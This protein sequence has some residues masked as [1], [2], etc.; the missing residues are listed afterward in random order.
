MPKLIV[1]EG[2][3]KGRT[4]DF[5]GEMIFLGRSRKNDIQ[6]L[7]I[8]VSRKHLKIFKIGKKCF[9]EDLKS[10][11]GTLING[12]K[13]IPG[14]SFEVGEDDVITLGHTAM[15][16]VDFPRMKLLDRKLPV[17]RQTEIEAVKKAS[18]S[19]G[20]R[21]SKTARE[22]EL[23]NR[24]SKL[25]KQSFNMRGFLEK[26]LE[27]VMD[28]LPRIDTAA[29]VLLDYRRDGRGSVKRVFTRIR[30][31]LE[32]RDGAISQEVIDQVIEVG[33]SIRMSD[34]SYELRENIAET[35]D[36]LRVGSVMCV[37]M[38]SNSVM[39]GAIYVDSVKGPYG[40]RK[41]DLLLLNSLSGSLA[42]AIEKALLSSR[43]R[44]S[45]R[46]PAKT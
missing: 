5:H 40:F 19:N 17:A 7:D 33:E 10:T 28:S 3:M 8:S 43:L 26:V 41:D 6:L 22:L 2:S 36:T 4:F 32:K 18:S 34:T 24:V 9:I 39:R 35:V 21:R 15:R 38:V 45:L 29:I 30:D 20:D 13:S 46:A 42:L 14:E 25:L 23:I 11:N 44:R 37:P 16:L 31:D 12:I 1:I 27:Y